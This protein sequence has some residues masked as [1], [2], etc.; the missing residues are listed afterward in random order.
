M[1]AKVTII[2]KDFFNALRA[3][4][5]ETVI[6]MGKAFR[7]AGNVFVARFTKERL[8]GR[9]GLFRRTG[10]L[11]RSPVVV[12][13]AGEGGEGVGM[14]VAIGG[15]AA[16]YA[17]IQEYGGEITG[18]PWLT[19]PI[20]GGPALTPSGVSRY[21]S[22]RQVPGLFF[23]PRKGGDP[24]LATQRG[25]RKGGLNIWYVLKRKVRIPARMGYV[26]TWESQL[27]ETRERMVGAVNEALVK[28]VFRG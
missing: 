15:P 26:D 28:T 27:P 16:P 21:P 22:A 23:I 20:P 24:L 25:G 12:V 8:S 3:L 10:S 9:P 6:Q 13:S 11:A 2:G 17:R 5:T 4:K 14:A 1:A 7:T 19:I 18:K